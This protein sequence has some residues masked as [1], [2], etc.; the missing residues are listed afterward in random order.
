MLVIS[1]RGSVL[2]RDVMIIFM[3]GSSSFLEVVCYA[4]FVMRVF[5]LLVHCV[6]T[7]QKSV[8]SLTIN[9]TVNETDARV[10]GRTRQR[11][12]IDDRLIGKKATRHFTA[13]KET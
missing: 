10:D 12:K 11:Q 6:K 3:D 5:N 4:F 9:S 13:C 8:K 1:K 2:F 7:V